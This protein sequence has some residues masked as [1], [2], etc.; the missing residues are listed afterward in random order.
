MKPACAVSALATQAKYVFKGD[1]SSILATVSFAHWVLFVVTVTACLVV[2]I[3]LVHLPTFVSK[4]SASQTAVEASTVHRATPVVMDTVSPISAMTAT[5]SNLYLWAVP[6]RS[7]S[8][9]SL[10]PGEQC[11]V[12]MGQPQCAFRDSS[13][14]HVSP[15]QAIVPSSISDM[16]HGALGRRDNENRRTPLA[17]ETTLADAYLMY[18]MICR[19]RARNPAD[20]RWL[21]FTTG[22]IGLIGA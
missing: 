8:N 18:P 1:V 16:E 2:H 22:L 9:E 17:N 13:T 6:N 4:A 3:S 12:S 14:P 5:Q 11:Y 21:P 20:V 19:S 7:V 15:P 10:P